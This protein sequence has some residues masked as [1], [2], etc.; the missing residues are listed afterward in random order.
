MLLENL[1]CLRQAWPGKGA[2]V[3]PQP[4]SAEH[5]RHKQKPRCLPRFPQESCL[6]PEVLPYG[7]E[8]GRRNCNGRTTGGASVWGLGAYRVVLAPAQEYNLGSPGFSQLEIPG[9]P[10][11][12]RCGLVWTLAGLKP[13]YVL[14]WEGKA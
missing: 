3:C 13:D 4:V 6:F 10:E 14:T 1:E 8:K 5:N 2:L 11:R 7:L 12:G 9:Q